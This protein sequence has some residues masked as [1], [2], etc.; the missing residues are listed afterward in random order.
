VLGWTAM[1]CHDVLD[2]GIQRR[3]HI[4]LSA[5]EIQGRNRRAG[6]GFETARGRCFLLREGGGGCHGH[7]DGAPK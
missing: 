4:A 1:V 5:A 6:R 7:G 2:D 3:C